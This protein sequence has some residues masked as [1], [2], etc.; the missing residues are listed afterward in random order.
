M[1]K[2][3]PIIFSGPMVRALLDGRKTMTRRIVSAQNCA[4]GSISAGKMTKLF[5][6]HADWSRAWPDRGFPNARGL[7]SSGYLHVP[8]HDADNEGPPECL[9]CFDRGWAGTS[10]RLYPKTEPGDRLWVRE[11]C[12][13]ESDY[14]VD[15]DYVPPFTDGRPVLY[16]ECDDRGRYWRQP[17]YRATD[18]APE[19]ACD[20]HEGP[21]CH[22]KPAIH[23][24]RWASRLTLIVTGVKV[25]RLQDI[26]ERDAQAEGII[27]DD[28]SEP[29]IW[30]VPGSGGTEL[31]RKMN[32]LMADRPSK[33]FASLWRAL[34][35]EDAWNANP[36]VV[37]L[38][39]TVHKQNIDTLAKAEAA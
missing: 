21:C 5:W 32:P 4:F 3:I 35:G 1:S 16:E 8:C 29:D 28:G 9:L 13:V 30:Y 14:D 23:M 22:W 2:D 37:A 39:F 24:P 12:L 7:Y 36:Y 11:T 31:G 26:S 20:K 18:P 34:H 6:E 38:T 10:H 15:I 19:M 25:E 27:E 17:H 33:V